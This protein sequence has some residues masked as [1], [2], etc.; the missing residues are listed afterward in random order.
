MAGKFPGPDSKFQVCVVTDQK[1]EDH[2]GNQSCYS[3]TDHGEGVE[4]DHLALSSMLNSPVAFMQQIFP[5]GLDPGTGVVMLKQAGELGGIILGQSNSTRKGNGQSGGGKALGSAQKVEQ[6]TGTERDINIAPDIKEVEENGVKIRKVIEKGKQHKL[7]LLDGL[8]V[9]GALFDIAG[10]RLPEIKNV[11]T[12]KQTNSQMMS[13]QNLQQMAG[14]IMSLGQMIQGLA[15][16]TGAGG[17]GGGFGS[18]YSPPSS[19]GSTGSGGSVQYAPPGTE[20]GAGGA[21]YSGGLGNNIISAVD[22][23]SNTPLY[24]IMEGLTPNMKAAVN[25]LSVL[26]QG[27][28]TEGGVAFMT[29]DV[30]HEDTYLGNA[31]QLLSKANTLSDLMYVMN[32]LQWDESIRGTEKLSNVVN[33]IETAWGV[34][35]QEIDY[36]GNMIITYGSEDANNEIQFTNDM[37]SN[38][39]SPG[40]GFFDGN[41]TEDVYY[42]VNSTGASLGFGSGATSGSMSQP[43]GGSKGGTTNAGQVIGQV[44]GLLGQIQGLAQGMNQNM[45]GESAGTMKDMWKRMTR[46]QENDAKGMHKKLNQDGDTQKM[47]QIAEKL[48]KG[49]NPFTVGLFD[50]SMLESIP[51]AVSSNFGVSVN[52]NP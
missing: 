27:Y 20:E 32:R 36:N 9:H 23:P 2:S 43:S 39:G 33:E 30:V 19:T 48:V 28:E 1:S 29:G 11:P 15:G 4:L 44:Q 45:F 14:Q 49:G 8:P 51:E 16:N 5:G 10:F 47:S 34:A 50:E 40:L 13:V 26:L 12:A 6:L 38:T 7:D 42:S 17:G 25:S 21:G 35:L 31:Q 24:E 41:N 52:P 3:P 46:E 18:N 22:A 37:T